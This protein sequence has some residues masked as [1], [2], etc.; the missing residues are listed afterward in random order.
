MGTV[1]KFFDLLPGSNSSL[2]MGISGTNFSQIV[3]AYNS[4]R[5][6]IMLLACSYLKKN[7]LTNGTAD[8]GIQ[9]RMCCILI[10]RTQAK[11]AFTEI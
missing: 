10:I 9:F 5:A 6:L 11:I 3:C 8:H 2:Y 7:V 1:N 4:N